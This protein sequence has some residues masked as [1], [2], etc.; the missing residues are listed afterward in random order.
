MCCDRDTLELQRSAS[1]VRKYR[2]CREKRAA[3]GWGQ[4]Q[5]YASPSRPPPSPRA[6]AASARRRR[7]RRAP[8]IGSRPSRGRGRRRDAAA[9]NLKN[10]SATPNPRTSPSTAS[11]AASGTCTRRPRNLSR[12]GPTRR[13][14][15]RPRGYTRET[16]ARGGAG[17]PGHLSKNLGASS[18]GRGVVAQARAGRR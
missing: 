8:R 13:N 2:G 4:Q 7:N 6:W 1:V 17:A 11:R 9:R 5:R 10:T 14:G 16:R 18:S 3:H 12:P 15:E